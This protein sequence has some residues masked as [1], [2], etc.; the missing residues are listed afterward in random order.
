MFALCIAFLIFAGTGMK[1]I[2]NLMLDKGGALAGSDL[3]CFNINFN[4][5]KYLDEDK[6]DEFLK[7]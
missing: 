7:T 5:M 3:F 2:G 6:I 1:M 4:D